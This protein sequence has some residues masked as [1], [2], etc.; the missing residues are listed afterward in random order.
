MN[1]DHVEPEMPSIGQITSGIEPKA[2]KIV[3]KTISFV[4]QQLP[5]WR[6]DP[7][8]PDKKSEDELNLQLCKFL[9]TQARNDFPMVRFNHEEPQIDRRRVGLSASPVKA[10]T[11]DARLYTIYDPVLVFEC[12]RFPAP[13]PKGR[14]KEYVTGGDAKSG[15][16]QRFKLGLHGAD[17]NS[18]VMIAYVQKDSPR[19][20]FYKVNEWIVELAT[21]R[22]EDICIWNRNELLEMIDKCHPKRIIRCKSVHLRTDSVTNNIRLFHFAID[23]NMESYR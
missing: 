12:K 5:H 18:A 20:W 6:D 16:I 21:G 13:S 23:M 14:E 11:I 4:H 9:D 3:P 22:V 2:E 15:G 10:V 17:L 7:D 19:H 1:R 8:R